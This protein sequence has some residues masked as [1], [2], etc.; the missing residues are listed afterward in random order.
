MLFFGKNIECY[1]I[2]ND[3]F[4][5]KSDQPHFQFYPTFDEFAATV[6]VQH[7]FQIKRNLRNQQITDHTAK[8]HC[9]A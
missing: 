7:H 3:F 4:I 1:F 5:N 8:N 9:N 6:L 2:G